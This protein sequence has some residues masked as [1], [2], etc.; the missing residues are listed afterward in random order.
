MLNRFHVALE[1]VVIERPVR[2]SGTLE[3]T[4]RDLALIG[5]LRLGYSLAELF[6]DAVLT[7]L[8]NL[9]VALVALLKAPEF[10]EAL[11]EIALRAARPA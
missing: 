9:V 3:L 10:V 7:L 8:G 6:L 2:L 11:S 5:Y 1:K 4:Q